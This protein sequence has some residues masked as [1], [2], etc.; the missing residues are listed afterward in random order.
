MGIECLEVVRIDAGEADRDGR[1]VTGQNRDAKGRHSGISR[2]VCG[3]KSDACRERLIARA[4]G[5]RLCR[6]APWVRT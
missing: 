6:S 4:C 2:D 5:S 1:R 3:W